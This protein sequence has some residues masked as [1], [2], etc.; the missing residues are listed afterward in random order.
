M[1]VGELRK[2]LEGMPAELPVYIPD[3]M[4]GEVEV[5]LAQQEREWGKDRAILTGW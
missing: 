3:D 5:R 4:E 2:A 1:T